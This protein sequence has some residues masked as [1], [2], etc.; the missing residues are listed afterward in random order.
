MEQ[1]TKIAI[2]RDECNC[3]IVAGPFAGNATREDF[4]AQY[5]E[6]TFIRRGPSG[7]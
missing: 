4:K 2:C 5:P 7:I 1:K 3:D 6:Y